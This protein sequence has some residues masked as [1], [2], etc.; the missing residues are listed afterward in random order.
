MTTGPLIDRA[1]F[2]G[3][4]PTARMVVSVAESTPDDDALD[5]APETPEYQSDVDNIF[6]DSYS[7]ATEDPELPVQSEAPP[8]DPPE[9]SQRQLRKPRSTNNVPIA[10][11]QP[12]RT[13]QKRLSEAK[14]HA[15]IAA[16]KITATAESS[17]GR[18]YTKKKQ[19]LI[20][21]AKEKEQRLAKGKQRAVT[22]NEKNTMAQLAAQR[23]QNESE[24]N[25]LEIGEDEELFTDF[26]APFKSL[27]GGHLVDTFFTYKRQKRS[28]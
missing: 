18:G 13:A 3:I 24:S 28:D 10:A 8:E 25:G 14:H 5:D 17:K 20:D 22:R 21:D 19:Q 9:S 15:A 26:D 6:N 16:E 1:T 4:A 2:P 23:L 27:Q 11:R 12:S 7:N